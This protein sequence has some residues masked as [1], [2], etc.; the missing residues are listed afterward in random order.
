M[1]PSRFRMALA[2]TIATTAVAAARAERLNVQVR[3]AVL[4]ATPSAL[5][6]PVASA[7]YAEPVTVEERRPGWVRVRTAAGVSG[8]LHESAVTARRLAL[9]GGDETVAAGASTREVA[10]AGKGFS[11]EVEREF[12][13]TNAQADFQWVD[14]MERFVVD[15]SRV[16]AFLREGGVAPKGGTR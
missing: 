2:V 15:Y 10:L 12:R 1:I 4:R 13:K 14:R 9:R 3:E 7:K 16:A 6:A 11:E 8:W 5:G